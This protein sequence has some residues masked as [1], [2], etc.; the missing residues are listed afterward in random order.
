MLVCLSSLSSHILSS[1]FGLIY[2]NIR[3]LN[4]LKDLVQDT[5]CL[6]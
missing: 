6:N 5:D 4:S 1:A 2:F 3:H